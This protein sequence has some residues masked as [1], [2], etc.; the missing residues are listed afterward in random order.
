MRWIMQR[1]KLTINEAKTRVCQLPHDR[2]DFLGYNF[3]RCYSWKTGVPIWVRALPPRYTAL[4]ATTRMSLSRQPKS[5][6][7][8]QLLSKSGLVADR[9]LCAAEIRGHYW[10]SC[11]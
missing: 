3:G 1:L 4:P 9:R 11:F 8:I 10:K 5:L 2:L 6:P 7:R